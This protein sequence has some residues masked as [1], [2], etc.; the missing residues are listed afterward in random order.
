VCTQ[1]ITIKKT[2]KVT[3]KGEDGKALRDP[4]K[5]RKYLYERDENGDI[6][7]EEISID[8]KGR[9][10]LSLYQSRGKDSAWSMQQDIAAKHLKA[11]GF[12][13]GVGKEITNAV[14]LDKQQHA[15]RELKKLEQKVESQKI[16][17]D[18]FKMDLDHQREAL[19][20]FIE[21]REAYFASAIAKEPKSRQTVLQA[22]T[23]GLFAD[24]TDT[25]Q[26]AALRST[27]QRIADISD[28]FTVNAD[29][30]ELLNTLKEKKVESE[31]TN[32]LPDGTS[33]GLNLK[34]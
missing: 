16:L 31:K 34:R 13:R 11:L 30:T 28:P 2:K 26:D 25:I 10:P 18:Q 4:K 14:H 6:V 12:E 17:L 21:S 7:T 8:L 9:A 1:D 5:P 27:E 22:A 23:V 33:I 20:A 29:V 24:L 32:K 19:D 15:E 3:K